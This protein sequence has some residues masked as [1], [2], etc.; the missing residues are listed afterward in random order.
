MPRPRLPS[1]I[2][3]ATADP[4]RPPDPA[5][6]FAFLISATWDGSALKPALAR[7]RSCGLPLHTV[8]IGEGIVDADDYVA[9]L[10]NSLDVP[11][12][13]VLHGLDLAQAPGQAA[14]APNWASGVIN[15][16]KWVVLNGCVGSPASV[17]ALTRRLSARGFRLGLA[18]PAALRE[19]LRARLGPAIMR[20]AVAGLARR[21]PSLSARAGSWLWQTVA[22]AT[23]LGVLIGL[24]VVAGISAQWLLTTLLTLPFLALVLLRVA[25]LL[26]YPATR[27]LRAKTARVTD[28]RDLPIYTLL[29][30]LYKEARMLPGL[31]EALRGLDYPPAK[32]DIKLILES[33]D[34]ETIAAA[35]RLNLRP[36]FELVLVPDRAPRSKPK[37]LNYALAFARGAYVGVF[38]AED[39]PDP[40]QLKDVL[41]AFASAPSHIGCVQGR[42]SIHNAASGWLCRQFALEYLILFEGLLP[43]LDRLGLP[44]PLGGTTNH[45]PIK[46][47]RAIGAWDAWNV[48]EDADLGLRLA[49]LGYRARVIAT[50]TQ[51]EAPHQ[52]GNWFRQRSRWLKGWMQT[53]IVH[54]RHPAKLLKELGLWGSLGF[55]ALFGGGILSSLLYPVSLALFAAQRL[56]GGPLLSA[57]TAT[58]E[59][60]IGLAIFNLSTGLGV[61]LAHGA[62]CAIGGRRWRLLAEV[63]MMPLYWL[64]ISFAA[65]RAMIQLAREPFKW[66]KTEHGRS[67]GRISTC[68]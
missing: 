53:Y 63:P 32:L 68:S 33:V 60:M 8:L 20:E 64:L 24:I 37:A 65:Y 2:I 14:A 13:P 67:P 7:A 56:F 59:L 19:R 30:P 28:A 10:A 43:A 62:V 12:M 3:A 31:V 17:S 23:T 25:L 54:S 18:P 50:T 22:L 34:A 36:P 1:A 16:E 11:F 6:E 52:F 15:G 26:A 55:H 9:R 58:G 21:D 5:A 39:V 4:R 51:E 41:A 42:L 48:T 27:S 40:S 66:E 35:L 29:V 61:A 47:L 44:L 38:D 49:R 45:F 57:E 46:V